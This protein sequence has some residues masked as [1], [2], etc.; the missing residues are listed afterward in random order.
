MTTYAWSCEDRLDAGDTDV[1]V[2]DLSMPGRDGFDVLGQ[3]RLVRP[4]VARK[5]GH[6]IVRAA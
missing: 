2:L 5:S 1:L 4:G 6:L 3:A